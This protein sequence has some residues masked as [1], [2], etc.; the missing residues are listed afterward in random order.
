MEIKD[1]VGTIES[2]SGSNVPC[3]SIVPPST[4]IVPLSHPLLKSPPSL[5]TTKASNTHK[6]LSPLVAHRRGRPC[7]KRKVS[8]VDQIVNRFKGKNKKTTPVQVP[9]DQPYYFPSMVGTQDNMYL[10]V[11]HDQPYYF[12]FMVGTQDS[13]YVPAW[14]SPMQTA[15][16]YWKYISYS[17]RNDQ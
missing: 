1:R 8:K 15:G 2:G 4:S 6:V 16:Q 14:V 13:I 12:P 5:N 3:S 7:T 10:P 17:I 11:P 9:Q